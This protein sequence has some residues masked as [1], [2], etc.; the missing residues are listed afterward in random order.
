MYSYY[1]LPMVE[2]EKKPF[3]RILIIDDEEINLLVSRVILE[4]M[5]VATQI[6]TLT[7]AKEGITFI[8]Q[9]CLDEH[10]A[11]HDCPDLILL[12]LNMPIMDG[13]SFLEALQKLGQSHLIKTVVVVLTSS[14][15][16]QD[17]ERIAA[18]GVRAYLSKPLTVEKVGKLVEWIS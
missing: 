6:I 1:Y 11:S 4:T 14:L 10:A 13:F 8:E 9:Y 18:F 5:Q 17:Q 12:D 15:H 2:R 3:N 7:Q 16:T